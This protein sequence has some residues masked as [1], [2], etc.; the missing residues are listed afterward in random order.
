MSWTINRPEPKQQ[1]S[2]AITKRF[3]Y[4]FSRMIKIGGKMA[5][6]LWKMEMVMK[7]AVPYSV[8][9]TAV[10]Q[11]WLIKNRE[12]LEE[13]LTKDMKLKGYVPVLD[14]SPGLIV[15]YNEEL[16]NFD[17]KIEMMAYWV[18]PRAQ[19]LMGIMAAEA[20]LI[21]ENAESVSIARL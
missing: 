10:D 21:G 9:G 20:L 15:S 17:Y 4:V 12:Y 18:G 7:N 11:E 8:E 5:R 2:Y 14:M 1:E 13:E 16:E 19:Y 3:W 6:E